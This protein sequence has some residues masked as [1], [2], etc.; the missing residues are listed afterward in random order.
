MII[1]TKYNLNQKVYILSRGKIREGYISIIDLQKCLNEDHSK[2][3]Y[4][5]IY[6]WEDSDGKPYQWS[7]WLAEEDVFATKEE[8]T[9][10]IIERYTK[11]IL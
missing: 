6:Y 9:S 2:L 4:C 3:E 7:E 10:T 11:A 1:K 5:I 8:A